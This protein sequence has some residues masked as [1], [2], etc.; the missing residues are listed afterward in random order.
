MF[1]GNTTALRRPHCTG[2]AGGVVGV[3]LLRVV[4][5]VV[6]EQDAAEAVLEDHFGGGGF[7]RL[8]E[9]L[10]HPDVFFHCYEAHV[11]GVGR[12]HAVADAVDADALAVERSPQS[13]EG[14][15]V[16]E[17]AG[18]GRICLRRHGSTIGVRQ[19]AVVECGLCLLYTSPSPRDRTRSRM[20]SSA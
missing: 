5:G 18:T 20:P 1:V 7:A 19:P 14:G 16:V 4:V 15:R 11:D 3:R 10:A 17:L 13:V 12:G 2:L 6:A 8:E 9:F